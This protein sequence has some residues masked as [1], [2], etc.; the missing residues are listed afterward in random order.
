MMILL[1]SLASALA[2]AWELAPDVV[3]AVELAATYA[4]VVAAF[5]LGCEL[6]SGSAMVQ[7]QPSPPATLSLVSTHF[8]Y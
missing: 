2:L 7:E 5:A 3:S 4:V 1:F 8:P 6:A